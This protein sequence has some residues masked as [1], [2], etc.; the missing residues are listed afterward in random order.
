[1]DKTEKRL[2]QKEPISQNVP[3]V[4]EGRETMGKSLL[5]DRP[6]KW[7]ESQPNDGKTENPV[8]LRFVQEYESFSPERFYVKNIYM[9]K[10]CT[11]FSL[12]KCKCILD[13][14]SYSVPAKFINTPNE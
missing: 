10:V 3:I 2:L 8:S 7:L 6:I 13:R 14:L 5:T 11:E 4:H 9:N 1:M 12:R